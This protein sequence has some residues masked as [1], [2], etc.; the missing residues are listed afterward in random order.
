LAA[1]L[2]DYNWDWAGGE[3]EFQIALRLNPNTSVT[4]M[5]YAHFLRQEGKLEESIREGQRA[6]ALDPVSA[7][8]DFI[9]AQSLYE[10]GRYEQAISRL[11]TALDLEPRFWPAHLYLG[12]TLAAQGH[13]QEAIEEL[14]KAGDFTAE[15]SATIGYVY[16]RMGRAADARAVLAGLE[17]RSKEGYVAPSNFAKVYIGL[18]DKGQAFAWLEKGYQLHD[19]WITFLKGDPTFDSLRSDPHFQNLV[20][21]IG[22]PQ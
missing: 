14:K 6:V 7:Q 15:P 21:R 22:F 17:E 8:A 2:V 19:F 11:R 10:A 13:F 18:G 16:G 4:H 5:S 20:S 3:K 12:K 1:N 9:L